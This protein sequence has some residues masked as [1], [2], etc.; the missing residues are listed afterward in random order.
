MPVK[1]FDFKAAY[2]KFDAINKTRA[3]TPEEVNE[4]ATIV[5]R[6]KR[7]IMQRIYFK[8][9][10]QRQRDQTKRWRERNPDKYRG[11][12]DRKNELRR[13]ST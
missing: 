12:L 10:P 3:L 1:A 6:E 9:D 2:A 11:Q 13:K 7:L 8:S 4:L 5:E